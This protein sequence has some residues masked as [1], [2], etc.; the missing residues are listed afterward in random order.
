MAGSR[1]PRSGLQWIAPPT[2][3]SADFCA[4]VRSPCDDLSLESATQRRSLEVRP[5]VLAARPPDLPPWSLIAVD[6]AIIGS[7]VRPG[8]PRYLVFV[9]RAA[10]LLYAFFR[11]HLAI[12]PLC[13][14]NSSPPSGWMEVFHLQ[15]VVLARHTNE[16]PRAQARGL[17]LTK[18]TGD[19]LARTIRPVRQ[20]PFWRRNGPFSMFCINIDRRFAPDRRPSVHGCPIGAVVVICGECM[21]RKRRGSS[22]EDEDRGSNL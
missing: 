14:A 16:K 5:S 8:R 1:P 21:S 10:A 18:I 17:T 11:P 15:A 19:R 13:R 9:H 20:L 12:P 6:F 3:P 2:M 22:A 7:L 4:S